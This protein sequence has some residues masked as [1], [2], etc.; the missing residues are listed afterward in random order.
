MCV[1]E[2]ELGARVR[3]FAP[4]D[5]SHVEGP[6]LEF[7]DLGELDDLGT[8]TDSPAKLGG[9]HPVLLLG[10]QQGVTHRTADGK[11]NRVVEVGSGKGLDEAMGGP[12]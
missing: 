12:S 3:A 7:A 2:R 8:V 11:A 6:A 5:H 10:E 1:K 4:T 9:R